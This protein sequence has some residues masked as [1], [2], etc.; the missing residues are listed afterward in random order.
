MSIEYSVSPDGEKHA[1]PSQEKY[2]SELTRLK[3]EVTRHRKQGR[4]I[5]VV[6]GVGFV[7]V[8]MAA[9]IADTE[10]EKGT[11]VNM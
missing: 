8:A 3:K 11:P 9:V 7:G 5:V 10:D 1:L 6:M 2:K 4:E